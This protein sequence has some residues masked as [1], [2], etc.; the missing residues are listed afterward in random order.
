MENIIR[1]ISKLVSHVTY[2]AFD[3]QVNYDPAGLK[4]VATS[5]SKM[6]QSCICVNA[7]TEILHTEEECT[8]TYV[9]VPSQVSTDTINIDYQRMFCIQVNDNEKLFIP[10]NQN[11]SFIFSGTFLSHR[12]HCISD[13]DCNVTKC[14]IVS[15]G[16]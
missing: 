1:N 7:N 16:N 15:Y 10:L 8:Y 9:K 2:T 5:N 3:M 14:F 6:W 4:A 11:L 12:Q 13:F